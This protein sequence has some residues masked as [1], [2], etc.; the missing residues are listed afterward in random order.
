MSVVPE[1]FFN[2]F[3][4]RLSDLAAC[5]CAQIEDSELPGLCFCGVVPGDAA[6]GDHAGD[7]NDVCGMG[8][9]RLATAYPAASVGIPNEEPGNCSSG[10]GMDVEIGVLRCL[11]IPS[12][13]SAPSAAAL[14]EATELQQADMLMMWRAVMCCD[15]FI[16]SEV[17]M[18]GYR[19]MGPLGGLVGGAFT[20]QTVI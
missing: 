18:G 5:L 7:C 12:D 8:W 16:P 19:P 3:Y 10:M 6:V 14:A 13:G 17:K 1:A 20:I 15:A 11:E 4:S 9:V 2:P